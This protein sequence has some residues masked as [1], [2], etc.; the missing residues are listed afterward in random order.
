MRGFITLLLVFGIVGTADSFA[1]L[2]DT[3]GDGGNPVVIG[4]TPPPPTSGSNSSSATISIPCINDAGG[5]AGGGS[6]TCKLMLPKCSDLTTAFTTTIKSKMSWKIWGYYQGKDLDL[7]QTSLSN[8]VGTPMKMPICS[9]VGHTLKFNGSKSDF[10]VDSQ[11][12]ANKLSCGN[13]PGALGNDDAKTIEFSFSGDQGS[14]WNSYLLGAYPWLIR[15]HTSDVLNE[16]APDLSNIGDVVQSSAAMK[17]QI[18]AIGTQ[19]NQFYS[20]L[21]ASAQDACTGKPGDKPGDFIARCSPGSPNSFSINDPAARVCQMVNSQ[22]AMNTLALPNVL[23]T[24]IM[25]RVQKQYDS[26]FSSLLTQSNSDFN[27]F[28][29]SCQ[30][31]DTGFLGVYV[32][33]PYSCSASCMFGGADY[34]THWDFSVTPSGGQGRGSRR[35]TMV[36]AINLNDGSLYS[37]TSGRSLLTQIGMAGLLTI[38]PLAAGGMFLLSSPTNRNESAI[39]TAIN[40]THSVNTGFAGFIEYFIR[41]KICGQKRLN[42]DTVCDSVQIPDKPVELK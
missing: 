5:V 35:C 17:A 22:S 1:K 21:A 25:A 30:F 39:P 16:L 37:P 13:L 7:T 6:G 41:S 34:I 32:R 4:T 9:V 12:I 23:I 10:E 20:N 29:S 27:N 31:G 38:D 24:E 18:A 42:D 11:T 26:M 2:D 3:S 19:M 33:R 40:D 14:K 8:L 15:K 28:F 36:A